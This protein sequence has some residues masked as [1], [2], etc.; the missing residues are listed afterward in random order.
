MVR[1]MGGNS[2]LAANIIVLT[3]MGSLLTTSVL[4]LVLHSFALL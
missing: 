1:A 4:M 2:A 3:T